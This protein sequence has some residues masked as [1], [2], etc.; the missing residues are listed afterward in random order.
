M[1][2]RVTRRA[3]LFLDMCMVVFT[4]GAHADNQDVQLDVRTLAVSRAQAIRP[5]RNSHV[6]SG[7][8]RAHTPWREVQATMSRAGQ[9]AP[10]QVIHR[11]VAGLTPF[12]QWAP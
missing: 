11:H 5:N 4:D 1:N 7:P 10:H 9:D 3:E 6:S 2:A 12:F 8:Q